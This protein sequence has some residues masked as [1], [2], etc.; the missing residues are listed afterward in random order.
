[1][2]LIIKIQKI[3]SSS[4]TVVTM[5]EILRG[6]P[7][8]VREDEQES[9][10][11]ESI[12]DI[13]RIGPLHE[14]YTSQSVRLANRSA[15]RRQNSLQIRK[16]LLLAAMNRAMQSTE[17]GKDSRIRILSRGTSNDFQYDQKLKEEESMVNKNLYTATNAPFLEAQPLEHNS[18]LV[19]YFAA[20]I[21]LLWH[22]GAE[23]KRLK[24][25]WATRCY[26]NP[27]RQN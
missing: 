9:L 4:F 3:Q 8:E 1:M 26:Q 12:A 25:E 16:R 19:A 2:E 21:R 7:G 23:K 22:L 17:A 14:A 5:F 11:C 13:V 6:S 20:N 24:R 27:C 18:Q 10:N 15:L